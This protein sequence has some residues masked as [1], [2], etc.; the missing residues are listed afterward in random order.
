MGHFLVDSCPLWVSYHFF[1]IMAFQQIDFSK[2]LTDEFVYETIM[3]NY[4]DL[5]KEWIFHQ[6][7]WMNTVYWAFKD[8]Y[9][10]LIVISLVEKTLQF[11]DKMS[12]QYS[13]D[14]YYS[15]SYLQIEKFSIL[16]ICEKLK[17]PK[18]TVRRKVLELEKLGVLKRQ[19]KKNNY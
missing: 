7:N 1:I 10:Y 2:T 6:W 8:H 3:E 4:S 13:F 17:L 19:K 11:Y 14:E 16:E 5:S 9:K 18:E 12:I 15:K